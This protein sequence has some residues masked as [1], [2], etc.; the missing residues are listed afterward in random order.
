MGKPRRSLKAITF[1]NLKSLNFYIVI[2]TVIS[3]IFFTILEDQLMGIIMFCVVLINI[4]NVYITITQITLLYAD[5]FYLKQYLRLV[6][7]FCF[8]IIFAHLIASILLAIS[9][10]DGTE[11]G[12]QD[13]FIS[14]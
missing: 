14:P 13:K 7:L 11:N 9:F 12:W 8:N 1:A 5:T 4:S 3:G 6:V 2:V 10:I